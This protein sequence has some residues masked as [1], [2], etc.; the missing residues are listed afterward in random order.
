M[1]YLNKQYDIEYFR[2]E[3]LSANKRMEHAE[4]LLRNLLALK[5]ESGEKFMIP[6]DDLVISIESAIYILQK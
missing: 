6:F 4:V 3:L 5:H 2:S 1:Y